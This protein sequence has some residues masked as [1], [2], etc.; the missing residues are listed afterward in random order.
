MPL[1]ITYK[2]NSYAYIQT[3]KKLIIYILL[4]GV[5]RRATKLI[6]GPEQLSSEDREGQSCSDWTRTGTGK[7]FHL[8]FPKWGLKEGWR[9]FPQGHGSDRTRGNDLK[10][11][12]GSLFT[13][14]VV[15]S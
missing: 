14:R 11:Q 1:N 5:Q 9:D 12:D 8:P 7:T 15:R 4:E 3:T 6:K 13:V 2:V 10:L